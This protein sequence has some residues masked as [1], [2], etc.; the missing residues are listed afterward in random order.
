MPVTHDLFQDLGIAKETAI[1]LQAQN[2]H[3]AGLVNKYKAADDAVVEAEAN[4]AI[5]VSD[6]KLLDLKA[7]RLSIKDQVA[8]YIDLLKKGP[9]S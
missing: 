6:A 7:K 1:T 8:D 4:H 5:G 3:L 9:I 2:G